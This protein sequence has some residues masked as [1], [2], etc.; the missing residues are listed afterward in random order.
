VFK[1]A[2]NMTSKFT[3]IIR[4]VDT[5]GL[6]YQLVD[7]KGQVVGRLASQLAR[8]LQGKD[9][10]TY[11]PHEDVGNVVVVIN[12]RHVELTGRKWDRKLYRWHT[13]YPGGLKER[14][15][16]QVH[17]K[18]PSEVLRK[19]VSG[20]LP[21]NTLRQ[22]RDRKLRIFP[23]EDHPFKD[24]PRLVHWQMPPRKLRVKEPL[25]V[26]EPHE[27]PMNPGA[28]LKRYGHQLDEKERL[29]IEALVARDAAE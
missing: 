13:G 15:A 14:T 5:A 22:A 16:S 9:Q 18:D 10:P 7:A 28:Y 4:N 3:N 2:A 27:E 29:R 12:A 25:W 17:E 19:A 26:L 8:L 11:T 6:N 23:D 1:A 24:H 21:K 20:M